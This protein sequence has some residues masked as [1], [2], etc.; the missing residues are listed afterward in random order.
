MKKVEVEQ[1]PKET[2]ARSDLLES[3]RIGI[4]LR[5]VEKTEE[6]ARKK[7]NFNDVQ[8]IMDLA[9]NARR[10]AVEG[11]DDSSEEDEEYDDEWD[12]SEA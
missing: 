1:P 11:E 5:K 4:T 8:A 6:A 2:D 3:I 7:T 10:K 12:D 9:F